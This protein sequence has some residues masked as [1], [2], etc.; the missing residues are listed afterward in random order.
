MRAGALGPIVLALA[1][2]ASTGHY[3]ETAPAGASIVGT[4][5][6]NPGH[7]SDERQALQQ[8]RK[9]GEQR[10]PHNDSI[11]SYSPQR[12]IVP[13][14]PQYRPPI[15]L[16]MQAAELRGGEWLHIEQRGTEVVISNGSETRSFTPGARSVVSV[17]TGV[18]DQS[19]GWK[20]R[21][22]WIEVKPQVGPRM[23]ER[24]RLSDDG[25]HLIESISI[26]SEGHVPKLDLTRVYDP[27]G[28]GGKSVPAGD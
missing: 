15:D 5:K 4:W 12:D 25:M 27:A 24:Y 17:T 1:A 28:E 2:C 8:A 13:P 9:R 10:T 22:F 3:G 6:L 16:S 18:A 19:S 7:S 11:Q 14:L 20:G 23:V 21:E 26:E